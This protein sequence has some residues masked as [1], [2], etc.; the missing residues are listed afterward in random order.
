M[1]DNPR[2]VTAGINAM[3]D[4]TLQIAIW[5]MIDNLDAA[6]EKDY[7]QVFEVSPIIIPGLATEMVTVKV[8]HIQEQPPY[9]REHF[10]NCFKSTTVKIFVIDDSTH[11]TML[12]AEEY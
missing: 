3:V 1:F 10:V 2:Y 12:L 6:L 9:R 5:S 4:P 7:L 11:S 8:A